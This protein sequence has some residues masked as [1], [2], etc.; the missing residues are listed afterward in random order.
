M[1]QHASML[2]LA[3]ILALPLAGCSREEATQAADSVK[4]TASQTGDKLVEM[5]DKFVAATRE[6]MDELSVQYD[7]LEARLAEAGA[8]AKAG[9]RETL[10]D[11]EAKKNELMN[12][13]EDSRDESN[14]SKFEEAKENIKKELADLRQRMNNAWD[15][16]KD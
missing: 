16:L 13:L 7:K 6:E 3:V 12:R 5:K 15:E 4:N 8:D 1:H 2:T 10:D 9:M 14:P 11:I